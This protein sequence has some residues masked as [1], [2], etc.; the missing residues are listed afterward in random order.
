MANT[1]IY[2][3]GQGGELPAGYPLS[4]SLDENNAQKGAA[5]SLTY[6]L[7]QMI[8]GE[9]RVSNTRSLTLTASGST[10][11]AN[12]PLFKDSLVHF[13]MTLPSALSGATYL[14][15]KVDNTQ[16]GQ[17]ILLTVP[18]GETTAEDDV[19]IDKHYNYV[20]VW[21]ANDTSLDSVNITLEVTH[22][23]HC[24][25]D[26]KLTNVIQVTKEDTSVW[27]KSIIQIPVKKGNVLYFC[28]YA[29]LGFLVSL[30]TNYNDAT[31]VATWRVLSGYSAD[32]AEGFITFE[33]DGYVRLQSHYSDFEPTF[34]LYANERL[35]DE[36]VVAASNTPDG[37]KQQADYV[38][39]GTN[40]EV[41]LNEFIQGSR[42]LG[43]TLKL[44]R[45]DYYL[46]APTKQYYAAND[47]FLLAE[48][49]PLAS[50]EASASVIIIG[51]DL[52]HAPKIHISNSAYEALNSNTQYCMFAVNN[53]TNYGGCVVIENVIFRL[54]WNQKKICVIDMYNY[55][56]WASIKHVSCYGYTG[57]YNGY[58]VS[59][60]NPPRKA[61]EG[62]IGIRFIAKGPNGGFASDITD[63]TI[64][65]FN[66]GVCINTEWTIC[67]HVCPFFCVTSWVFG[68][69]MKPNGP[70]TAATHPTVLI[71]CGSER[72]N[73]PALFYKNSG[74]Q[75]I[76][77][78]A[79]S[80]ERDSSICPTDEN[81][82]KVLGPLAKVEG[83]S[84]NGLEFRGSISYTV[85]D[86]SHHGG[87]NQG[88]VGFWEFGHGH[89][90]KTTDASHA[91]AGPTSLRNTYRPNFMQRYFDTSLGTNGKEIICIDESGNNGKGT[92]VD[93]AG[94]IV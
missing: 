81:G 1:N 47:T 62:C 85:Q 79:F 30:R 84:G 31:A 12:Y 29:Q 82:N 45:G 43:K 70:V 5:S 46:D 72:S 78:I 22:K 68:K 75:E 11:K 13:K 67:T 41:M 40:D 73:S 15:A 93:A 91:Q 87:V 16:T 4:T 88:N 20:T 9:Y 34:I 42:L 51:E 25:G 63:C 94:N 24:T 17:K 33:Q 64:A 35:K 57:G 14:I 54:P 27:K 3:Y 23:S 18:S 71:C 37:I 86:P 53:N 21:N 69:Y 32:V 8:Q 61:V 10:K 2:P 19:V 80:M 50:G 83:G 60:N 49:S 59:V 55:G 66:E 56:G 58:V 77:I 74:F 90:M 26:D 48:T 76:E 44:L 7:N 39:T 52:F 38:C 28:G 89:G 6:Q 36:I 92:W 65:G